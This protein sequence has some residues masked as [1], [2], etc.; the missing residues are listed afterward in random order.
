MGQIE[1]PMHL[2][3]RQIRHPGIEDH[4]CKAAEHEQN[5]ERQLRLHNMIFRHERICR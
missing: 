4:V 3:D 2:P 1:I 5:T